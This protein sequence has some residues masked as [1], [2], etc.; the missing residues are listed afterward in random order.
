MNEK[1]CVFLKLKLTCSFRY[2]YRYNILPE[3]CKVALNLSCPDTDCSL[4]QRHSRTLQ[5]ELLHLQKVIKINL[6]AS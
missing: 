4:Y 3:R 2:I 6:S 5:I 1:L